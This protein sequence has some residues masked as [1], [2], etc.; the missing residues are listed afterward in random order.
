VVEPSEAEIRALCKQ[1][2]SGF[3]GLCHENYRD[4]KPDVSDGELWQ[5]HAVA[6]GFSAFQANESMQCADVY[7]A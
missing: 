2:R 1:G 4:I 5:R 7:P 3:A 6:T